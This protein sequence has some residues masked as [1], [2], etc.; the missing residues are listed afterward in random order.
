[1]MEGILMVI[2]PILGYLRGGGA[3]SYAPREDTAMKND[4]KTLFYIQKALI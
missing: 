3:G 2:I 4:V 1:M